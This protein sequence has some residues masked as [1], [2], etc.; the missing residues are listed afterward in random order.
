VTRRSTILACVLA[1]LALP[2]C[3]APPPAP[4]PPTPTI[5]TVSRSIA[6]PT[7][8]PPPVTAKS[9]KPRANQASTCDPAYPTICISSPPPRLTCADIPFRAFKVLR[10]DP[11]NFDPDHNGIGCEH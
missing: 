4:A 7:P 1:L 2:A 9:V 6:G 3:G 10:P 5:T 8:Q 11:H